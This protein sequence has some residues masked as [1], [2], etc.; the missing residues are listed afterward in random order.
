[1]QFHLILALHYY[2]VLHW[3]MIA[4]TI[5]NIMIPHKNLHPIL[6]MYIIRDDLRSLHNHLLIIF[7]S[8][9]TMTITMSLIYLA[10][11]TTTFISSQTPGNQWHPGLVFHH[12][13]VCGHETFRLAMTSTCFNQ[14]PALHHH[15]IFRHNSHNDR[16][17]QCAESPGDHH[18]KST[19]QYVC[20]PRQSGVV[21]S[22]KNQRW[23]RCESLYS[24]AAEWESE[25][26]LYRIAL[27]RTER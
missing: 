10:Q 11:M 27:V 25:W 7:S 1:M 20:S 9:T 6:P 4:T 8:N 3:A 14:N 5:S 21:S 18:P 16:S 24:A 12:H 13:L 22:Q 19:M 26:A 2:E 17:S 15:P 23:E